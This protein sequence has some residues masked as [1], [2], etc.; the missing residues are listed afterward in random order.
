M[1]DIRRDRHGGGA[2][3]VTDARRAGH[4]V[5]VEVEAAVVRRRDERL[6]TWSVPS[7]VSEIVV[8]SES[9]TEPAAAV[10]AL[11]VAL[12]VIAPWLTSASVTA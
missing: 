3:V 10:S 2:A 9:S 5:D 8:E 4:V 12:L 1:V 11:T 7:G 6:T